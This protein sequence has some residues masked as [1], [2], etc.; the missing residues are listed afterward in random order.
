MCEDTYNGGQTMVGDEVRGWQF[1]QVYMVGTFSGYPKSGEGELRWVVPPPKKPAVSMGT[2]GPV[3]G[4]NLEISGRTLKP[5]T[6]GRVKCTQIDTFG[7]ILHTQ[8]AASR[9]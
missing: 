8:G 1:L 3:E 7:C 9:G 5:E 4:V 6:R 2:H